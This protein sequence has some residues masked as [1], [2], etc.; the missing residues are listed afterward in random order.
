MVE[1]VNYQH[2]L[3]RTQIAEQMQETA[4]QQHIGEEQAFASE[5]QRLEKVREKQVRHSEQDE[6]GVKV[7]EEEQKKQGRGEGGRKE[8]HGAAPEA[9]PD[10]IMDDPDHHIDIT[11]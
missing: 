9:P 2:S 11:A 8:Q 6:E 4:K 1:P 5:L 10:E 3:A 7:R